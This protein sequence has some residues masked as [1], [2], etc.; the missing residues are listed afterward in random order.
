MNKIGRNKI[1]KV[2]S[3]MYVVSGALFV[4][5]TTIQLLHNFDQKDEHIICKL[6]SNSNPFFEILK[7][8]RII[9]STRESIL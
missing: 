2:L 6:L 3:N 4:N 9:L 5:I 7:F 8:Y 1:V